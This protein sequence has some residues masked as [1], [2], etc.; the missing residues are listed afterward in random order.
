MCKSTGRVRGLASLVVAGLVCTA[1]IVYADATITVGNGSGQ[2]GGTATFTVTLSSS[3]ATTGTVAGTSN[4]ITFDA[5]NTP[6]AT[7]TSGP[8]TC[9]VTTTKSC[10]KD[11]E[12]PSGETCTL[13][14]GPM[15]TTTLT[16]KNALFSFLKVAGCDNVTTQCACNPQT[17]GDCT[18]MRALIAG[19]DQPD[20]SA[21]P[22][23]TLYTCTANIPTNT[24]NGTYPLVIA[25][26][27][28]ADMNAM[29]VTPANG[30]SGSIVVGVIP[31]CGDASGDG[32][33]STAEAT[34]A[35]I[36]LVNRDV[37]KNPAA[38][39]NHDG[40]ISTAEATKVILNLVNRTCNS[41]S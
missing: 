37:T 21:I 33:V 22:D 3:G 39:G 26:V 41:C 35:I 1:G 16:N 5:A 7:S 23:G 13:T 30:V 18:A 40:V 12:C 2:A 38:D 31:C 32:S 29:P 4:D 17:A 27:Q 25:N 20:N 24:P 19:L 11:A 34:N 28:I 15:C 14:V 6:L 8:G 9:S 36:G 10:L